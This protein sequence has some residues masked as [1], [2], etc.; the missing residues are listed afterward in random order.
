MAEQLRI[1]L[2]DSSGGHLDEMSRLFA[3]FMKRIFHGQNR[4]V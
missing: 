1:C 3:L 4:V 2:V